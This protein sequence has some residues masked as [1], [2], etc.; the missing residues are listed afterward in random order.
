M[1]LLSSTQLFSAMLTSA[2][3]LRTRMEP[4]YPMALVADN[5][6]LRV[7]QASGYLQEVWDSTVE[8]QDI[9]G[10]TARWNISGASPPRAWSRWIWK[11]LVFLLSPYRDTLYIDGDVNIIAAVR[12]RRWK[13]TI[14]Q[15]SATYWECQA[16]AM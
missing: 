1:S 4:R 6:T 14:Q 10:N 13:M 2:Q 11:M 12:V 16:H 3:L 7:L 5:S 15:D 9:S 8:V